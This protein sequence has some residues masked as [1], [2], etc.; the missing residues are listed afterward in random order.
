MVPAMVVA[1]VKGSA[2]DKGDLQDEEGARP[3]DDSQKDAPSHQD[4]Y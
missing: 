4:S 1:G 2:D 3:S